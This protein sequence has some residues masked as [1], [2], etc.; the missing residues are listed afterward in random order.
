MPNYTTVSLV[1]ASL[2]IPSGT[3]S[4]DAYIEDA[5][6]AAEDEINEYCGRTFVADGSA[7]PRVYQPSTNVIVYTDDF[8]SL[9]GLVVKQDESDDGTYAT[10]LTITSE[11]IVIGN[12]APYNAIRA[13]SSPF[14]SLHKRP[15]YG[16]SNGEMGLQD[17]CTGSSATSRPNL[18][19]STLST[20]QQST[21]Y[22]RRNS[23]RLWAYPH[24]ATGSRYAT[25]VSRLQ[26]DRCRIVADYAAIKDGIKTRLETLS[27][28]IAVFDTVPDRA[29]PPVAVVVPGAPPVE[30]NVSMGASTNAS[31]L[32]R[33]NFEILVLAQRFYAETAQDKLDSYVSGTGSVYNAIAGD[34]TLGGT[35]S[36][37][38]ITRVADY[39]QIV[40]G[41][42]EFMGARLDLEVYAV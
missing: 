13:V 26:A 8:Y 14:P 4:E 31:Q 18:V 6:D 2:G 15:P 38:R 9:T 3:T 24:Y 12:S 36:D 25:L 10:T 22:R 37:A 39:G 29:V 21:R 27:G 33:F 34:T 23:Q 42:G 16:P 1:K 20:S 41:E 32:Q 17:I 40:V 19:S 7:T 28:L 30:Y 11:F 35:A 5:I